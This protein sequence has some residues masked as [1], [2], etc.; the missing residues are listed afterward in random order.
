MTEDD[1]RNKWC[2]F[3]RLSDTAQDGNAPNRWPA[4]WEENPSNVYCIGPQ[5]MAWRLVKGPYDSTKPDEGYCGLA[6]KP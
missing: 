1:A 6:G 3:V 2:P 5:C 4:M